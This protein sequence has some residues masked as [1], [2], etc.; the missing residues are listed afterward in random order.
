MSL[1]GPVE[2]LRGRSRLATASAPTTRAPTYDAAASSS[3]MGLGPK[4]TLLKSP[5]DKDSPRESE[6][7]KKL[8]HATTSTAF[9]PPSRLGA[10]VSGHI[11]IGCSDLSLSLSDLDADLEIDEDE[12]L[13]GDEAD[14]SM[15]FDA[16]A[17]HPKQP[18]PRSPT[19]LPP[20]QQPREPS[21]RAKLSPHQLGAW[22]AETAAGGSASGAQYRAYALSSP[23]ATAQAVDT[24]D[25]FVSK[26]LLAREED[27][28][29]SPFAREA[30]P[31]IAA[32]VAAAARRGGPSSTSRD[33]LCG[34]ASSPSAAAAPASKPFS[35]PTRTRQQQQ[36]PRSPRDISSGGGGGVSSPYGRFAS[37][38]A[39]DA[40]ASSPSSAV[41]EQVIEKK[42]PFL[43]SVAPAVT[44]CFP[45]CF[46]SGWILFVQLSRARV[47]VEEQRL[48]YRNLAL[49]MERTREREMQSSRERAKLEATVLSMQ[50]AA[51]EARASHEEERRRL[52]LE[53]ERVSRLSEQL[54]RERAATAQEL[55]EERR[56]V[57]DARQERL[58]T[59]QDAASEAERARHELRAEAAAVRRERERAHDREREQEE[60]GAHLHALLEA[61]RAE[62]EVER[63][64]LVA[65]RKELAEARVALQSDRATLDSDVSAL[66]DLGQR[67]HAESIALREARDH[68]E[69]QLQKS[70]ALATEAEASKVE[71]QNAWKQAERKVWYFHTPDPFSPIC[72]TPV[73]PHICSPHMYQ[74]IFFFL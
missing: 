61:Q 1:L 2:T 38:H 31:S 29:A 20:A 25:P 27:A 64:Q 37:S 56:L 52:Q 34:G 73:L 13:D 19:A 12:Y 28:P 30:P 46:V 10:G 14:Y 49:E 23:T 6:G 72:G 67:V 53:S 59:Q 4:S 16:D 24:L 71:A 36:Q 65:E 60:A 44:L 40:S 48:A 43:P 41:R 66:K 39:L 3:S 54:E 47:E 70:H 63:Q 21:P 26:N 68:S 11:G 50:A 17:P 45:T 18:S 5:M 74:W 58:A 22:A 55:A 57:D 7:R 51:D 8:A 42:E 62:L 9:P 15:S 69:D 33:G 32:T 35:S